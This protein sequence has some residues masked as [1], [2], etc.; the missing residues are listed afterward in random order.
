MDCNLFDDES[1]QSGDAPESVKADFMAAWGNLFDNPGQEVSQDYTNGVGDAYFTQLLLENRR[2]LVPDYA[3]PGE[4]KDNSLR[5]LVN[6]L[7]WEKF[8]REKVSEQERA[9]SQKAGESA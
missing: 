3:V 4:F 1:L 9:D 8:M 5:S 6:V 2:V 7:I